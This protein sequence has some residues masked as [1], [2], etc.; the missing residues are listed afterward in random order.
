[1]VS[2]FAFTIYVLVVVGVAMVSGS[3]RPTCEW[4][5]I[6]KLEEGSGSKGILLCGTTADGGKVSYFRLDCD[7][8][9]TFP[10]TDPKRR[11]KTKV[12]KVCQ[13]KLQKISIVDN[14]YINKIFFFNLKLIDSTYKGVSGENCPAPRSEYNML[15]RALSVVNM[16]GV[17]GF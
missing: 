17:P 1:M 4:K 10:L 11:C 3:N 15:T 7:P 12:C 8:S 6:S 14:L 9:L 5:S 2:K 13:W 16:N